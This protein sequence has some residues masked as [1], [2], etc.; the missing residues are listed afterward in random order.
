LVTTECGRFG[1]RIARPFPPRSIARLAAKSDVVTAKF[2]KILGRFFWTELSNPG[3]MVPMNS[4]KIQINVFGRRS[5]VIDR[6]YYDA[7][8]RV[9]GVVFQSGKCYRYDGVPAGI[10]A[11]LGQAVSAGVFFNEQIKGVFPVARD[12]QGEALANE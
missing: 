1:K 4:N 12:P 3:R 6:A 11:G 9:L 5:S 8:N 10:A 2:L 7:D